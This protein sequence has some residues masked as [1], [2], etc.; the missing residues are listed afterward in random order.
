MTAKFW[1]TVVGFF[2]ATMAVAYPWHML[3]FHEQYV[4]MGAFTRGEPIMPFG[5]LAIFLQGAV[6][7]YF[8]PLFLRHKGGGNS[9]VRGI[10]FSLF[11]GLTVYSVMVFATAAKFRIEP[12]TEFVMFGTAFQFLQFLLVGVVLGLIHRST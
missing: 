3:M 4:A 11:L 8:F 6:F 2:V 1:L 5:M 9:I 12:V 7:A 10:Q